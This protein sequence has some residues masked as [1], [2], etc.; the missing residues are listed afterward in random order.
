MEGLFNFE[1][2]LMDKLSSFLPEFVKQLALFLTEFGG[3]TIIIA[4]SSK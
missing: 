1:L 2:D 3:Q 4:I